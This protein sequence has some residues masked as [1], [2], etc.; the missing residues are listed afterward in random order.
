MLNRTD[1][2]IYKYISCSLGRT[3]ELYELV[4]DPKEQQNLIETAEPALV[5]RMRDEVARQKSN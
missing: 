3:E 5:K 1:T 4:S 2:T